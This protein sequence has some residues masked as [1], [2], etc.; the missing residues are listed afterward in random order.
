MYNAV[1]EP[2]ELAIAAGVRLLAARMVAAR[3]QLLWRRLRDAP[4]L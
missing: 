3:T 2:D 4:P 1:A